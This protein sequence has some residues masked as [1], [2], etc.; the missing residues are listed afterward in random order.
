M[1][2]WNKIQTTDWLKDYDKK[3][4]YNHFLFSFRA[5]PA[6]LWVH[7]HKFKKIYFFNKKRF[8]YCFYIF[9]LLIFTFSVGNIAITSCEGS[10]K[11]GPKIYIDF[12][13]IN[14]PCNC[15]ALPYFDGQLLITSREIANECDTQIIVKNAYNNIRF[16]CP[17]KRISTQTF[18]V[19]IN[20]LADI[21]AEYETP[22]TSGVFYHCLGFQQNGK[23]VY[24]QILTLTRN[25]MIIDAISDFN[26][27]FHRRFWI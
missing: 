3:Y 19:E 26:W 23:Y 17:I 5:M 27:C 15:T 24:I 6:L 16:G 13:K 14:R 22:S 25:S 11:Y 1:F 8:K 9:L 21:Q 7:L 12:Y 18:D 2:V 10:R 20:Q 4:L